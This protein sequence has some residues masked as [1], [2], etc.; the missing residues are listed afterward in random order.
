MHP[1]GLAAQQEPCRAPFSLLGKRKRS[2]SSSCDDAAE[3][4]GRVLLPPSKMLILAKTLSLSPEFRRLVN[5]H[6]L[7]NGNNQT[8]ERSSE[9][10]GMQNRGNPL[11]GTRMNGGKEPMGTKLKGGSTEN[12]QQMS[13]GPNVAPQKRGTVKE[14]WKLANVNHKDLPQKN[15]M[16]TKL[17]SVE[18]PSGMIWNFCC[19]KND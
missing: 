5:G 13:G 7:V 19:C 11:D 9:M 8:A 16:E 15:R 3:E 14:K 6:S 12:V 17:V 1:S 4:D 2:S 18:G 10:A